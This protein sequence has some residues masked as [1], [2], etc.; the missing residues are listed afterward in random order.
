MAQWD[1]QAKASNV[2]DMFALY[3]VHAARERQSF[4]TIALAERD[5]K[6][7][8]KLLFIQKENSKKMKMRN[9]NE[10]KNQGLQK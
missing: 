7:V 5:E 3:I 8:Q 4:G 1:D 2:C 6:C 10:V 9:T